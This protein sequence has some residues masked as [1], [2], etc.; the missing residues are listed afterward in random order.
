MILY[1]YAPKENTI[2][3]EGLLSTSKS[4]KKLNCY[5]LRAGSQNRTE[6]LAWLDSTFEGRS[7]SISV[8]TEPIVC[9]GN[10]S[11]L[12]KITE[13]SELY[14]FELDDLLRDGIVE[15]IWCKEG[16]DSN[17]FNENFYP[18]TIDEID[19]SP[20]AWNKCDS[21]K[22]LLF[23][24]IRHYLLVLKDGVIPPKYLKKE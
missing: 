24:V 19:T 12:K 5:S 10:D 4:P 9:E 18:V 11:V 16:S 21:S 8:L 17:G 1:H 6:I 22:D 15:K 3:S 13:N 7:K 2:S 20:L 23:A 14:S